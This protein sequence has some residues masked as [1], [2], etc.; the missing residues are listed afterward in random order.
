MQLN[1]LALL[2]CG[3]GG[4][5]AAALVF[6][7][8]SGANPPTT[9]RPLAQAEAALPEI[10]EQ[11]YSA[12]SLEEEGQI[13][14]ALAVAVSGDLISTLYLQ[15]REAQVADHAEDGDAAIIAVEVYEVTPLAQP[16]TYAVAWRVVG[17]LRHV[18]HVH[19]RINLY[20]AELAVAEI[21]GTWKLTAFDLTN[22]TRTDDLPFKGGE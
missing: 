6:A 3:V 4:I 12:F 16:G 7:W 18:N 19:E 11:I 20:S 15:R 10:L 1:N 2:L 17:R 22:S 14:D 9:P 13:Y 21:H 5:G 8:N